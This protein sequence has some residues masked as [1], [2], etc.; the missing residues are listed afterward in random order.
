MNT[1]WLSLVPVFWLTLI[2][3]LAGMMFDPAIVLGLYSVI[4]LGIVIYHVR[5]L[6]ALEEWLHQPDLS[7]STIPDRSGLWGM[8]FAR[9]ARFVRRYDK[10]RLGL[11]TSLERLQR[12]TSA[13]PEGVVILGDQDQIEWCNSAAE[14]HLGLNLGMDTGQ[15]ITRMVRQVRFVAY[16]EAGDFSKPFLLKQSRLHDALL[17][18]QIVP[19]GDREKLLISRDVTRFEKIEIMRRDFIAN[20]S[21]ELRTPLT[22]IG[23]FLET[24]LEDNKISGEMEKNALRLMSDQATRMRRL[25]EDLLTLSRLENAGNNLVEEKVDVVKLLQELY[26]EAQSLSSGRHVISLNLASHAM[27]LG[28]EDELRSAF[29]NLI[30]NAV[31][32]TPENGIISLNWAVESGKGIFYVQDSGIGIEPDHI[33]RLTERFYRVDRSRS[34]ETGGTGLGLAIV[35]HVLNRHQA[36]MEVTSQ[37]GVGSVFRIWFPANRVMPVEAICEIKSSGAHLEESA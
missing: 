17:L 20:V 27:L 3:V 35:K 1:F 8:V 33:P 16:L 36:S 2:A 34:R 32:Y 21:H 5:T 19:Y 13:L 22:V 12:A 23:G 25:V 6:H 15:H 31:R 29:E 28:S 24:L 7:C 30:S 37:P 11:N 4:L 14:L 26:Q 18:I 9:L 10:E